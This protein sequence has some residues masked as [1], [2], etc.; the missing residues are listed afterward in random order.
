VSVV[1]Q[2]VPRTVA[3]LLR[4]W[5]RKRPPLSRDHSRRTGALRVVAAARTPRRLGRAVHRDVAYGRVGGVHAGVVRGRPE[6]EDD[7]D[8]RGDTS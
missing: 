6:H 7:Q 8:G 2:E 3:T 4:P 1:I 5:V